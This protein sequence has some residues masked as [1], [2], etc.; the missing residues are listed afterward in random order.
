MEELQMLDAVERYLRGQM[1]PQEKEY[2]EQLRKTNPEIDQLI[3]AH[4]MFL[5]Q[6]NKYGEQKNFKTILNEVHN[7][8]V[9]T[10]D[11]K[12]KPLR[13]KT[14]DMFKRNRKVWAVAAC[15]AGL[16]ALTIAGM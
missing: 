15:I 16:T 3:V 13:G 9:E 7:G 12:E 4:S 2:F 11:I 8:L 10:G 1:N 14:V 6:L 5:N